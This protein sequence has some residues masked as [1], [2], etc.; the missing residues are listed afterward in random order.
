MKIYRLS[1]FIQFYFLSDLSQPYYTF[2][3][4]FFYIHN[5]EIESNLHNE[6]SL[7]FQ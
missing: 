6:Q 7:E 4:E 5:F 2:S 1:K 3:I